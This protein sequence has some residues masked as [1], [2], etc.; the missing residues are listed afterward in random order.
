MDFADALRAV[1]AGARIARSGWNGR[2]MWVAFMPGHPGGHPADVQTA[3]AHRLGVGEIVKV[4][5][6]LVLRTAGGD[7]VPWT[8]SQTDALAD[9]W[10]AVGDW[11]P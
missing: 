10:E 4:P 9:D 1:K 7:L 3:E 8:I 5:P 11:G 2:G 6:Y